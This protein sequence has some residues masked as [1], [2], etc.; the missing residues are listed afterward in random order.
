MLLQTSNMPSSHHVP[1]AMLG[2]HLC[3]SQMLLCPL[4]VLSLWE[5]LDQVTQIIM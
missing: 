1:G 5:I 2:S 4:G 3:T